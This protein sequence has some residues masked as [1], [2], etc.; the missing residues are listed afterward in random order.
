VLVLLADGVAR[1]DLGDVRVALLDGLL[2]LG[3]LQLL[4]LAGLGGLSV[5]LFGG[6]L[7]GGGTHREWSCQP[8]A[9]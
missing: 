7:W 5:E 2:E 6:E 9:K 1:V 8:T 4:V 3:L